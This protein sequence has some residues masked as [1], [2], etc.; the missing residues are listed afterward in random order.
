MSNVTSNSFF[1]RGK[2]THQGRDIYVALE[3]LKYSVAKILNPNELEL[4]LLQSLSEQVQQ[5]EEII[6]LDWLKFCQSITA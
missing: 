1:T 3:G 2:V 5:E 6:S 4:R